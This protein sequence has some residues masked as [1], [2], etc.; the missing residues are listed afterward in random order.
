LVWTLFFG[1]VLSPGIAFD[2]EITD[3]LGRKVEV[4]S[5]PKRIVGLTDALSDFFFALGAGDRLAG[6]TTFADLPPD[7]DALPLI[8]PEIWPEVELVLACRPDLVVAERTVT[9]PE[10][11]EQ[12]S[13]QELPVYVNWFHRPAEVGEAVRRLG[14]V[15]DAEPQGRR[16]ANRIQSDVREVTGAVEGAKP[17]PILILLDQDTLLVPGGGTFAD[18]MIQLAGGVNVAH[19]LVDRT[20]RLDVRDIVARGP[21]V[22]VLATRSRKAAK[23]N[24]YRFWRQISGLPEDHRVIIMDP[25]P[26]TGPTPRIGQALKRLARAAHPEIMGPAEPNPD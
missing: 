15:I 3:A 17:T 23:R 10:V 5:T 4:P 25:A 24:E 6:K 12:L 26:L 7:A 13:D 11:I 1:L 19:D 9:P 14:Q 18:M 2:F 22:I 21:E 16:L 8:G 20:P